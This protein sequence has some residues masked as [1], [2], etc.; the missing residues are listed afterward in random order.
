M[1]IRAGVV[2]TIT[3][4]QVDGTP[5]A[6]TG[7]QSHDQSLKNFDSR[8]EE[9]H[10]LFSFIIKRFRS[11]VHTRNLIVLRCITAARLIFWCTFLAGIKIKPPTESGRRERISINHNK[12]IIGIDFF[13]SV[14]IFF[15]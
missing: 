13:F 2:V 6:E 12:F 3:F 4:Q 11:F 15:N 8:V 7:T 9:F 10:S 14:Q 1:S 5:H